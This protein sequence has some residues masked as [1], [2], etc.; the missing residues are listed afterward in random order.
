MNG[1]KTILITGGLGNLGLW[2]VEKL[3]NNFEVFVLSRKNSIPETVLIPKNF[4]LIS[5]DIR[6]IED[7]NLKIPKKLDFIIHLAS[8][9]EFFVDNYYK[10]ALEINT[11]GTRNII[12]IAK[13]RQIQK[14][15]Y[16]STFHIYGKSS[17]IV[18]EKTE[19]DPKNDY[20]LTHYFAELYIKQSNLPYLILRLT[21]S[22]GAPK[23]FLT[24]KWYL[25]LNDLAKMAFEKNKIILKSN[26][27]AVRDFIFMGDVVKITEKLFNH[28]TNEILNLGSGKSY[29][30]LFLAEIVKN[31]YIKFFNKNIEIEI[32]KNDT[33]QYQDL[34]VDILK[35]K[36]IIDF[37]FQECFAD[38]VKKIFQLLESSKK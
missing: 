23:D 5:A 26:G 15:I 11:L 14:L 30:V 34:T 28:S 37:Q 9:N 2:F 1:K 25:V 36:N 4:K 13:T 7:L 27:R 24:S 33:N 35:L 10:L 32:N 17:G 3:Q 20:A 21:N 6:N 16:F 8:F 18:S 19:P 31:E 12:E 38:E 29:S 22:Y